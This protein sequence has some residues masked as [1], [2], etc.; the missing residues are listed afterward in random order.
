MNEM[1]TYS[2][3]QMIIAINGRFMVVGVYFF[4]VVITS[5]YFV[6]TTTAL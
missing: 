4:V 5:G 6:L 1:T 3:R 2:T